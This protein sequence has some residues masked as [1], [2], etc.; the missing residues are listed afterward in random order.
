MD[1]TPA[2]RLV[3]KK[4]TPLIAWT[5]S[6]PKPSRQHLLKRD[7]KGLETFSKSLRSRLLSKQK[8]R[9]SAYPN[10]RNWAGLLKALIELTSILP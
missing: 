5:I 1:S 9:T 4:D 8:A 7:C 10:W 3:G 6:S 2:E